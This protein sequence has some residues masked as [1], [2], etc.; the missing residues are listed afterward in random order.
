A[1]AQQNGSRNA[2]AEGIPVVESLPGLGSPVTLHYTPSMWGGPFAG[3]PDDV[4]LHELVH[5]MRQV[6][7]GMLALPTSG[8]NA[9]YDN[10][11]E[12]L[13]I[14]LT[15]IALSEKDPFAPLRRDHQGH[16]KLPDAEATSRGFLENSDQTDNLF[17]I[18]F[19]FPQESDLFFQVAASPYAGFN[20]IN[21]FLTHPERYG[22]GAGVVNAVVDQ[23]T[24]TAGNAADQAADWPRGHP[25]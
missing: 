21:E 18:Q 3:G 15:N 5:A 10:D 20:P 17:W 4:L 16:V 8:G 7:G 1:D 25:P 6:Q 11:E 19:L 22:P 24:D 14:L 2:Y 13:A 23:A 12:F 9:G